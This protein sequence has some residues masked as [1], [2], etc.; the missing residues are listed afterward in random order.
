[1]ERYV[2]VRKIGEGSFGKA[3]LVKRKED[4]KQFVIKEICISK[5]FSTLLHGRSMSCMC[6]IIHYCM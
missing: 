1:M 2:R 5:V 4:G 6:T 3:M